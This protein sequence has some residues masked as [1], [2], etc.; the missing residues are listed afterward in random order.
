MTDLVPTTARELADL[1]YRRYTPDLWDALVNRL[2]EPAATRLW[3]EAAD[4]LE[5]QYPIPRDRFQGGKP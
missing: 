4:L 1:M 3:W 2:G 5:G